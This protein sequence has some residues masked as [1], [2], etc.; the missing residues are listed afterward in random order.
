MKEQEK[1]LEDIQKEHDVVVKDKEEVT[2]L[3]IEASKKDVGSPEAPKDADEKPTELV[4]SLAVLTGVAVG[5]YRVLTPEEIK[6]L[7]SL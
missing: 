5:K 4:N 1:I 3:Y 2:R 7:K 6:Y